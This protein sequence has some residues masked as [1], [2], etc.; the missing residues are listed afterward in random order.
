MQESPAESGETRLGRSNGNSGKTGI[1]G[2]VSSGHLHDGRPPGL[3]RC[4]CF[5]FFPGQE[6]GVFS[7]RRARHRTHRLRRDCRSRRNRS[8]EGPGSLGRIVCPN[9][10]PGSVRREF[11]ARFFPGKGHPHDHPSCP[12]SSLAL[13]TSWIR[14]VSSLRRSPKG[15]RRVRTFSEEPRS[16][17]R[18]ARETA[19]RRPSPRAP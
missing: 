15:A 1:R 11:P 2:S 3:Y 9:L 6:P 18:V 19:V 5:R 16:H 17:Q 13:R 14:A 4:Q 8:R 12:R 7:G 10:G